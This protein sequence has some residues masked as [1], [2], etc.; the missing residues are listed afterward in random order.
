[1]EN[2][3]PSC[4]KEVV[5][6][7]HADKKQQVGRPT[8]Q[9]DGEYEEII[10]PAFCKFGCQYDNA[11]PFTIKDGKIDSVPELNHSDMGKCKKESGNLN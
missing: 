1:M 10:L 4:L 5:A 9:A 11:F 6:R 2:K 8:E 7:V 3:Y